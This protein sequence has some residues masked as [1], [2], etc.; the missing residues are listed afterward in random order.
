MVEQL[1]QVSLLAYVK[2]TKYRGKG[3]RCGEQEMLYDIER[4]NNGGDQR[5]E[6][7]RWRRDKAARW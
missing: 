4:E 5:R 1:S 7:E 6:K 3:D 2:E